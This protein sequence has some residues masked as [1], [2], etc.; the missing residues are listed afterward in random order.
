MHK[1]N[2]YKEAF[3]NLGWV[4]HPA[5]IMGIRE[6]FFT[7]TIWCKK[8]SN[9]QLGIWLYFVWQIISDVEDPKLFQAKYELMIMMDKLKQLNEEKEFR[10]MLQ[11][12]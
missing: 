9:E 11:S 10:K 3:S 2:Y 1:M 6:S 7:G 4:I 12:A 5:G 8:Y